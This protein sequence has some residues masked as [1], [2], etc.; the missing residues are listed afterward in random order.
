MYEFGEGIGGLDPCYYFG[1]RKDLYHFDHFLGQFQ[2]QLG[3][4]LDCSSYS[5]EDVKE[6]LGADEECGP[7]ARVRARVRDSSNAKEVVVE[8]RLRRRQFG[9]RKG[10]F[11]TCM[12]K[13]LDG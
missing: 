12:V 1:F 3:E 4:L 2:N 5:I 8:F 13:K 11:M 9:S 6:H 10:A 7:E